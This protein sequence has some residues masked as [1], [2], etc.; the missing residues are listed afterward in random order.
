MINIASQIKNSM[1]YINDFFLNSIS[2]NR[3]E[4][5]LLLRSIV[6][7]KIITKEKLVLKK[8]FQHLRIER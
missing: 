1:H 3:L 4:R 2:G 6:I 8:I 7:L 5:F